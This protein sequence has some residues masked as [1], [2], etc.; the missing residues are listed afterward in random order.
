MIERGVLALGLGSLVPVLLAIAIAGQGV[1]LDILDLGVVGGGGA[2]LSWL[3]RRQH[4]R[5]IVTAPPVPPHVRLDLTR[6]T[7]RRGALPLLAF[8]PLGLLAPD[9]RGAEAL[10]CAMFA[11]ALAFDAFQ[12]M[13]WE[14]HTSKRVYRNRRIWARGAPFFH[15]APRR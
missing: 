9:G 3:F 10:L 6:T 1:R 13:R 14:R 8:L 15:L 11:G 4:R 12:L 2:V 7:L 5:S